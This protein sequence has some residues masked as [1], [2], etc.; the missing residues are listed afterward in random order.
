M[1]VA[2]DAFAQLDIR[3]GIILEA[4]GMPQARK[5]LYR[6]RVDFGP[7]GVKQCVAGI[8]PYYSKEELSGKRVVAVVNLEP[9][10]IA[11]VMSEC[12]L[13]ASFTESELSLLVPDKEM[14]L[15]CKV[16]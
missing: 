3:V 7:E 10:S 4:E 16:A 1:P 15:G 12:M 14:P 6:L 11:G 5:P 9:R 8:K 2:F 13:L